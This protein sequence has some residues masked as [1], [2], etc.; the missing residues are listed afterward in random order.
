MEYWNDVKEK[1]TR[2]LLH[3]TF[4]HSNIPVFPGP[5]RSELRV[6][7][8]PGFYMA[9]VVILMLRQGA[10]GGAFSPDCRG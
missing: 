10:V 2:I 9:P 3:A 1:K 7:D 8:R 5:L 6:E 4:H